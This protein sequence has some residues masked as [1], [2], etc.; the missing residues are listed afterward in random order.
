M[1]IHGMSSVVSCDLWNIRTNG[2]NYDCGSIYLICVYVYGI[3]Q[4]K[5]TQ[6]HFMA[7]Q[8][9]NT[10]IIGNMMSMHFEQFFE[11]S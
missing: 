2:L 4:F 3:D 1:E 5:C 10:E 8:E 7:M 6:S 11:Y 9:H